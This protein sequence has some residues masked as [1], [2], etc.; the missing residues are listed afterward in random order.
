MGCTT[1][2]DSERARL[3]EEEEEVGC[4]LGGGRRTSRHCF[5]LVSVGAGG[6]CGDPLTNVHP[7]KKKSQE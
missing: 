2:A 4:G 6:G 5:S 1:K 3:Q 7:E